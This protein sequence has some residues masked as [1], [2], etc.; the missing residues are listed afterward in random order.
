[1][2]YEYLKSGKPSYPV[3]IINFTR[4]YFIAF[5]HYQL[6]CVQYNDYVVINEKIKMIE[7]IPG[8]LLLINLGL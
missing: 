1:M 4:V 8:Y 3:E 7:I 2:I 6:L 5:V